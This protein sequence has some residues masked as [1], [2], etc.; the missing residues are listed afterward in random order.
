MEILTR[1]YQIM[2]FLTITALGIDISLEKEQFNQLFDTAYTRQMCPSSENWTVLVL[3]L[4]AA[5]IT[6][7]FKYGHKCPDTF[8]LL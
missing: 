8:V 7:P 6:E 4:V 1:L 2:T 3:W 5:D